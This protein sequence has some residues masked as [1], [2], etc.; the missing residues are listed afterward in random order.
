[1]GTAQ[2][3]LPSV[4]EARSR[5]LLQI[6][7]WMC[8]ARSRGVCATGFG[9]CLFCEGSAWPQRLPRRCLP[10]SIASQTDIC[11]KLDDLV[12]SAVGA[13]TT[14]RSIRS[15]FHVRQSLVDKIQAVDMEKS[16]LVSTPTLARPPCVSRP[17][18][19]CKSS[20]SGPFSVAP[21][22]PHRSRTL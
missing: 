5:E 11:M 18:A 19:R 12:A 13:E 14:P 4:V 16:P 21:F 1:M 6:G 17:R 8:N 9:P 22:A 20:L 15:A 7:A 2:V 10:K 3:H